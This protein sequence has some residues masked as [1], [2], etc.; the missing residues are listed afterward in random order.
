MSGPVR[1]EAARF[2]GHGDV[3]D[4]VRL[5]GA[6]VGEQIDERGGWVWARRETRP[7]PLAESF[8]ASLDDDDQEVWVGTFDDVIVGYAGAHVEELRDGSVLAVIDDV[9]VEPDAREVGVGQAL[10]D[11][12]IGWA[13]ERACVG[14]DGWALPGNRETKNFF[15][16]F[17]FTARGIVVHHRLEQG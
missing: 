11:A 13:R 15:E 2:A 14:V 12:V 3:D 9:Y 16:S 7:E 17:G 8:A 5:A 4:L 1:P 10:I 6:A